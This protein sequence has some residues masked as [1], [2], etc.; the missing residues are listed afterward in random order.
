MNKLLSL[1]FGSLRLSSPWA[2]ALLALPRLACG[3]ILPLNFGLSKFPPPQWFIE[4]I[5]RL[6]FPAPAVFAWAAVISEVIASFL[7]ALGFATRPMALLVM[8][9]MFVAAFVQKANAPLWE[10]LP[11][12]FF[13]LNAY[14]SLVLGSGRFGLDSLLRKRLHIE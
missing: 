10:R 4:D 14:F 12:L 9:T 8:I 7:L 2:D 11:S 13:F 1:A 6:G 5:G 3:I